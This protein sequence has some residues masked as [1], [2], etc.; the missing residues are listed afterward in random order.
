MCNTAG[1][2]DMAINS[3]WFTDKLVERQLSQR[4]LAKLMGLDA[5]AVSLMMRGKR[6]ITI[7]E[8]AQMA[9]LLNVTTN[10]VLEQ[11]GVPVQTSAPK[12]KIIGHVRGDATVVMEAPGVHEITTGPCDLPPDAVAIQCRTTGTPLELMDGWVLFFSQKHDNPAAAVDQMA[13]V[14]TKANGMRLCNVKRGYRRGT[15]NL[16]AMGAESHQNVELAW[17]SPILWI[18][19]VAN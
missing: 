15:Y 6:R 11:A 5:S 2:M 7:E 10:D 12:V 3:K 17:A 13:L 14:A 4:G 19:T 9:V 18:R 8:A 1:L 16:L